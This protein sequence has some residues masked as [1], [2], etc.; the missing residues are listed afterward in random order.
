MKAI[1]I[2]PARLGA[3]RYPN[4]PMALIHGMPMVGHCYHRTR[5]TPGI[6]A[7]YVATCDEEIAGY[8]RSIGGL[9]AMTSTS[10]TRATARTA[11]A[12][13]RIEVETGERADVVVMV[14]GDE[15]LIST[16]AIA[17]T[18]DHFND[19]AIE[20]VNIMSRLST[21]EQFIDKNNVKVVVNRHNDALYFS[22]EPIPSPWRGFE[23]I[24]M[25]M[26]TGIIAFRH[27][28]LLRFNQMDET[29]LEQIESVDMNRVLETGGRIRMVLTQATTIGVDTPQELK[30]AEEL[31]NDDPTLARYLTQ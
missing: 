17:E 30:D 18:L 26:Q 11:E 23:N 7:T 3:T 6:D 12:M 22:R 9:A 15:P 5:L 4:K 24:P 29:Q 27:D 28:A 1:G 14:Q 31:M 21:Y 2:I 10:H 8:V 19:P 20:I 25:Y 13:E 16:E